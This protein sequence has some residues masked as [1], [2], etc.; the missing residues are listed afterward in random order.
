[1]DI[2]A[3]AADI[4]ELVEAFVEIDGLELSQMKELW[5]SRSFSFIHEAKLPHV[6]L[7]FFMQALYSC[8]L[9][10]LEG[11]LPW[12]KKIGGL[13]VL[14]ILYETQISV[15]PIKIYLSTDNLENIYSLVQEAKA[16][17]PLTALRIVNR[18]MVGDFFLYGSVSIDGTKMKETFRELSSKAAE[19]V[20]HARKR[21]F[22]SSSANRHFEG[23]LIKDLGLDEL[24]LLNQE[25]AMVKQRV[26]KGAAPT[27]EDDFNNLGPIFGDELKKDVNLWMDERKR[28]FKE[29]QE[30]AIY[31][32]FQ[33]QEKRFGMDANSGKCVSGEGQESELFGKLQGQEKGSGTD[34]NADTGL[35]DDV[36]EMEL[37]R[38]L[39]EDFN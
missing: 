11:K 37:E 31:R 22:A 12:S 36:F 17:G 8:T 32:E 28:F 39:D 38:T 20:Q 35:D 1:M 19:H 15:P 9:D 29:G 5:R 3:F 27:T 30:S 34:L 14:Y 18:M 21:L 24:A 10:F 7:A 23:N 33:G 2:S 13:Y 6:N 16:N 25:Y 26:Y 4:D